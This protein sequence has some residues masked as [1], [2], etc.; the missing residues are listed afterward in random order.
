M[1]WRLE[2][3]RCKPDSSLYSVDW[4]CCNLQNEKLCPWWVVRACSRVKRL[5]LYFCTFVDEGTSTVR[6]VA[7]PHNVNSEVLSRQ[8]HRCDVHGQSE[9]RTAVL[10]R[11]D[12]TGSGA[13]WRRSGGS[14]IKKSIFFCFGLRRRD[15]WIGTCQGIEIKSV[16]QH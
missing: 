12:A 10:L 6:N 4:T 9:L 14:V 2:L 3:G 16:L 1:K 8:Q 11:S 15:S 13:T 7:Q 5:V